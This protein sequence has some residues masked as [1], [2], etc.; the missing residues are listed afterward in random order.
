MWPDASCGPRLEKGTPDVF[1]QFATHQETGDQQEQVLS[2]SE[3]RTFQD[4]E[5]GLATVREDVQLRSKKG[6]NSKE[7][8]GPRWYLELG[9]L[10]G[11]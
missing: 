1:G 7:T 10:G 6:K 5:F 8:S 9:P 2:L 11:D 4:S 3:K